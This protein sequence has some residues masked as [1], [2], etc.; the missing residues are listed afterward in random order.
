MPYRNTTDV[1]RVIYVK[2]DVI[3][4]AERYIMSQYR[5]TRTEPQLYKQEAFIKW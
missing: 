5:Q 3:H 4:K 2:S 1:P